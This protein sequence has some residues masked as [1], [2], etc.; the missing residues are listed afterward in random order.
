VAFL[1]GL[2]RVSRARVVVADLVVALDAQLDAAGLRLAL[3][4]ALGDPQLA[5]GFWSDQRQGYVGGDG[6]DFTLPG[7]GGDRVVTTLGTAEQPLALLAHDKEL[8]SQPGLLRSVSAAAALSLSNL[9]LQAELRAQ[10]LELR[11]SRARMA[12]AA[13][14]E[15]RRVERDLHDGAQQRL[16]A[17][18]L[19]LSMV[20]D[21]VNAM[22]NG[23]GPD[24]ALTELLAE[25]SSETRS[26]ISEL[27]DLA[28]GIHPAV[29]TDEG[30]A[31]AVTT[32]AER[33]AL[34]VLVN[35]AS[36]R[37]PPLFEATAYFVIAEAITN[38]LKHANA[39][40][41][42]VCVDQDGPSMLVRVTDDGIGG[43]RATAGS[44]LGGLRDRVHAVGGLLEL[45]SPAGA[46]TCLEVS[47]PCA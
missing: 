40:H 31:A 3:A 37:W 33:S 4:D 41:V 36:R 8:L 18:G 10:L 6:A 24:P 21:R 46:G 45:S 35:V 15:R 17:L 28:R 47:L 2:V 13:I 16:L 32:L 5:L 22:R 14:E 20:G 38:A 7:P 25:A 39:T 42:E 30:L 44:G 26:A 27:R 1:L 9:R 43:A 23:A 34:P 19:T 11:A 29:L 12:E